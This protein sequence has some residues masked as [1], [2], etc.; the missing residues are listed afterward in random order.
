MTKS[1]LEKI[2]LWL[3]WNQLPFCWLCINCLE[4]WNSKMFSKA[5]S[6]TKMILTDFDYSHQEKLFPSFWSFYVYLAYS[7]YNCVSVRKERVPPMGSPQTNLQDLRKE[8]VPP[9]GSPQTNLQD[10]RKERIPPPGKWFL[11]DA[12]SSYDDELSALKCQH[13][14]D[15]KKQ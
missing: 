10:L 12:K 6:R 7:H 4:D 11:S 13:S 8:R 1:I 9:M 2:L 3:K 5:R 14:K 15:N